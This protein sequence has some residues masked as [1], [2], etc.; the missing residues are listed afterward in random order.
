MAEV[1][2]VE[3]HTI[4][5]FAFDPMQPATY[6]AKT[7]AE[8]VVLFSQTYFCT[9][10]EFI[11][12]ANGGY[13]VAVL[14]HVPSLDHWVHPNECA[15]LKYINDPWYTCTSLLLTNTH[16]VMDLAV[17]AYCDL[18]SLIQNTSVIVG[19]VTEADFFAYFEN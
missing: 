11:I 3:P 19:N 2:Y 13:I 4:H 14:C 6:M 10:R 9:N 7:N 8:G 18:Y 15:L 17:P 12:P 1:I 16:P 5:H